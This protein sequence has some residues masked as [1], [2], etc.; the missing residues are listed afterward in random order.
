M[1]P[2]PTWKKKK[3][4]VPVTSD[5]VPVLFTR[6]CLTVSWLSPLPPPPVPLYLVEAFA[7]P[8]SRP[9]VSH[10][11]AGRSP[12]RAD[13]IGGVVVGKSVCVWPPGGV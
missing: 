11:S 9:R 1:H 7:G 4:C 2:R 13:R 3:L 5:F 10:S 8:F 6:Q 12:W